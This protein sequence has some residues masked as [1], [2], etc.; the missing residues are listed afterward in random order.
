M[1]HKW[2][3]GI[4]P[5]LSFTVNSITFLVGNKYWMFRS[6]CSRDNESYIIIH[7]QCMHP[8][9]STTYWY[10][11]LGPKWSL[12]QLGRFIKEFFENSQICILSTK[13]H[14]VKYIELLK[15][16][17]KALQG[18]AVG[19]KGLLGPLKFGPKNHWPNFVREFHEIILDLETPQRT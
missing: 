8:Q 12:Y 7:V 18:R 4:L 11:G 19:I 6:L 17:L 2:Q 14:F 5:F 9:Y 16:S 15:G 1:S 13:Q 10:Q 3:W